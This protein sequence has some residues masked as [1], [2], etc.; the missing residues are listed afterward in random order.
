MTD[1]GGYFTIAGVPPGTHQVAFAKNGITSI[2]SVDVGV[3]DYVTMQNVKIHGQ[4]SS[5]QSISHQSMEAGQGA[6]AN[7]DNQGNTNSQYGHNN[8][9]ENH[10][11]QQA[12][13]F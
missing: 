4:R 11:N 13:R 3:N 10:N 7:A 6:H 2:M 8:N 12:P 1:A 5:A 9:Q